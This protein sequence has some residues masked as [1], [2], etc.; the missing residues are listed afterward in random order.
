VAV[1]E[2]LTPS[3][4]AIFSWCLFPGKSPLDPVRLL[5]RKWAVIAHIEERIRLA[6]LYRQRA[7]LFDQEDKALA[8]VTP[9]PPTARA[10]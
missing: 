4:F 9:P 6:T 7:E 5:L 8:L 1:N 3:I 2:R 10:Q